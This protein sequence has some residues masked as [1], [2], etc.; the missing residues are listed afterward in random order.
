MLF[1]AVCVIV[2]TVIFL[3]NRYLSFS[4]KKT[5]QNFL[6][7]TKTNDLGTFKCTVDK[8]FW[9]PDNKNYAFNSVNLFKI[10][11][12]I[13]ISP[14]WKILGITKQ[15]TPFII[16]NKLL[17]AGKATIEN[18]SINKVDQISTKDNRTTIRITAPSN[19]RLELTIFG[20][21]KVFD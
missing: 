5:L 15:C 16:G 20:A 6:S 2:F 11:N 10:E 12:G 4:R 3:V 19:T 17:N 21:E 18:V 7:T 13:L 9:S 14:T 8:N 1:I